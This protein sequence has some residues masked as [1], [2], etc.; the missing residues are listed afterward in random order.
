MISLSG[1]LEVKVIKCAPRNYGS[2]FWQNTSIR[3]LKDA[4]IPGTNERKVDHPYI[5]VI[6]IDHALTIDEA[7]TFLGNRS[8]DAVVIGCVNKY[9]NDYMT[10]IF[11]DDPEI[12]KK[13]IP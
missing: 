6:E 2:E 10:L 8:S 13:F 3:V 4:K 12:S 1:C 5:A 11:T 7:K 9:D